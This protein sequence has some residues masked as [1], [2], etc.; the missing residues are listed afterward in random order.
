MEIDYAQLKQHARNRMALNF[1]NVPFSLVN[2]IDQ[3]WMMLTHGV[4]IAVGAVD[5]NNYRVYL[6]IMNS[7]IW[8]RECTADMLDYELRMLKQ[9]ITGLTEQLMRLV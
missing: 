5:D 4:S 2:Y 6:Y 3:E 9:F 7:N 1:P 8:T